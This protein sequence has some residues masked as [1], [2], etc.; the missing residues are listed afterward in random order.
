MG[1]KKVDNAYYKTISIKLT[2]NQKELI[3]KNQ[4]LYK[5]IVKNTRDYLNTFLEDEQIRK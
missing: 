4:W 1:R 3:N 2:D 5:E